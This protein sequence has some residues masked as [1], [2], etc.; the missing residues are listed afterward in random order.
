MKKYLILLAI[1]LAAACTKKEIWPSVSVTGFVKLINEN[2]LE[3]LDK[4]DVIVT[5]KGS[6]SYVKTDK[7]GKYLLTG[8]KSETSYSFDISKDGY[9]T[10][11]T[12]DYKFIGDQK[13]G[14][15]NTITLYQEPTI[16]LQSASLQYLNNV[17]TI[18]CQISPTN[19]FRTMAF[20]ND[21]ADLSD[22]H[23]DYNSSDYFYSGINY[24]SFQVS[25][26]LEN[27]KYKTG[28]I[29]Y[30]AIYFYNYYDSGY[31]DSET[32]KTRLSSANKEGVFKITL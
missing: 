12:V 19:R 30:V 31:W 1:T 8:L 22:T 4:N 23:Y 24:T 27:N 15:I 17:I 7:N 13:P 14:L 20:A 21:S 26:S 18:T 16:E 6:S 9:G 2:G 28:N 3:L 10:A 29:I 32:N 11:S 5:I 25:I